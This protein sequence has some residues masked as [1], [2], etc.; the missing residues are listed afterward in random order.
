[1]PKTGWRL[2]GG[3]FLRTEQGRIS[4]NNLVILSDDYLPS[5]FAVHAD[6]VAGV[7]KAGPIADVLTLPSGSGT[8]R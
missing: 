6:R 3:P 2:Y 5:E 1:M 4:Y 8:R 7:L